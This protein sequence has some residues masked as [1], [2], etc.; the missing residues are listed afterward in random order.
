MLGR[1]VADCMYTALG[2]AGAGGQG[3]ETM[4]ERTKPLRPLRGR[5]NL[6]SSGIKPFGGVRTC[7]LPQIV[8]CPLFPPSP[9]FVTQSLSRI[10]LP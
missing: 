6:I 8:P 7:S 3:R 9:T 4:G 2:T 1:S 10:K 5:S